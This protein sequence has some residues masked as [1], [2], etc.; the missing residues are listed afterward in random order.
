M[1]MSSRFLSA[2]DEKSLWRRQTQLSFRPDR[3]VNAVEKISRSVISAQ[4]QFAPPW[5]G[6]SCSP[7]DDIFELSEEC[8][9]QTLSS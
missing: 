2:G 7:F 3:R 5:S 9:A 4:L 1:V 6:E 8:N